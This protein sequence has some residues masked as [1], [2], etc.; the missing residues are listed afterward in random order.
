M[1]HSVRSLQITCISVSLG[2]IA[3]LLHYLK[4]Y[5]SV[6]CSQDPYNA[7]SIE[8]FKCV[9]SVSQTLSVSDPALLRTLSTG[10]TFHMERKSPVHGI[11]LPLGRCNSA[12]CLFTF[13]YSVLKDEMRGKND[14]FILP[15]MQAIR[16][17]EYVF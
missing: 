8:C 7:S 9:S 1:S 13:I 2:S 3:Y 12:L 11:T 4:M 10:S 17:A 5:I 15:V 14:R 6:L 16:C